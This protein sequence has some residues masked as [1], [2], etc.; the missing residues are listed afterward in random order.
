MKGGGTP[1]IT[2]REWNGMAFVTV[3]GGDIPTLALPPK[4]ADQMQVMAMQQQAQQA[5]QQQYLEQQQAQYQQPQQQQQQPQQQEAPQIGVLNAANLESLSD[6]NQGG[7]GDQM[8]NFQQ[9]MY[10][11]QQNLNGN[12]YE[13][14]LQQQNA[15]QQQPQQGQGYDQQYDMQQGYGSQMQ[16]YND[17]QQQM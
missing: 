14:Q 5:S 3:L 2:C 13:Q 4:G 15:Y 6:V 16:M 11:S 17:P 7:Y 1:S 8:Q 10:E 12:G 9:Q